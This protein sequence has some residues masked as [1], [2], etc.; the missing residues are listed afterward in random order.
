MPTSEKVTVPRPMTVAEWGKPGAKP[1][2][3]TVVPEE[4]EQVVLPPDAENWTEAEK[5]LYQSY[6]QEDREAY[7]ASTN[8]ARFQW[9]QGTANKIELFDAKGNPL[10]PNAIYNPN[11]DVRVSFTFPDGTK[12]DA[13]LSYGDWL[14]I[15]RGLS[16]EVAKEWMFGRVGE[17]GKP[18]AEQALPTLPPE[19]DTSWQAQV[20]RET[21]N[22]YLNQLRETGRAPY[23]DEF[24]AMVND[25]LTNPTPQDIS[26]WGSKGPQLGA[27]PKK[28]VLPD[29][30]DRV[31]AYGVNVSETYPY[32]S[33]VAESHLRAIPLDLLR[34]MADWLETKG[35]S[36][37]DYL[38][39][40]RAY[41]E[42]AGPGR[43]YWGTPKQAAVW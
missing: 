40:C 23:T 39:M 25:R 1:E 19:S 30:A 5:A 41:Y 32:V 4:K 27:V 2:A 31:G 9:A 11:A 12:W 42:G 7:L 17:G 34:Q 22:Y 43:V 26:L 33:P 24:W 6:S 8:I 10:A 20:V 37:S 35:I 13:T 15:S 21:Y 14:G 28:T 38:E 3:K 18:K 16:P 29:W 36:W